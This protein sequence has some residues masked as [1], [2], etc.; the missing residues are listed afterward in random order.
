MILPNFNITPGSVVADL[1][2]RKNITTFYG[3]I[4]TIH[5]LPYGR[6][7]DPLIMGNVITQGKGTCSTKHAT[8]KALAEEHALY[9]LQ[10]QLAIYGMKEENTKGIGKV[11]DK[12]ELP[13][14]LEAHCF[15]SYDEKVYDYTFSGN[16]TLKW[17][18]SVLIK[19]T[20]DTDQI[21]NYKSDYH[22]SILQDWI[23]RDKLPYTL[24]Q[25][26]SIREECIAALATPD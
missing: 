18:D 25:L 12:Y 15:L 20:I 19:T 10:L 26:W 3:A 2:L 22:K 13:Y 8:L 4:D 1:F 11:L 23:K 16:A 5:N 17:Q 24:E 14:M 6:T 21:G 9:G 7:K